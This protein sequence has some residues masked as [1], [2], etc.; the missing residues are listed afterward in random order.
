MKNCIIILL[1]VLLFPSCSLLDIEP[2][3]FVTPSNYY[4]NE[5]EMNTALNGIYATLANTT[6]FGNNLLG[7]M[8]LSADIGYESYSSD[9]GSVG[10]YDVSPTDAKILNYWRDLY[11]GI[12]RA[13]MLI[14]YI[15]KPQ[16]DRKTRDNI[17]GQALFLRA[18]YHFLLVVRFHHIPLVLTV[19]DDGKREHVQ[20]PQSDMREVYLQI[21]RD[22]EEAAR[23]V[24]PASELLSPGRASQS[25]VYGML[26][27]VALYMAGYPL[28]E[29]G[30]YAKARE[31]A[32]KVIDTGTHALNPSFEQV[33]I[34]YIQDKYDAGES[35]FEVEFWG[36]NEGTYTTTA[37]MV[38]RN[39]GIGCTSQNVT[40]NGKTIVDMYGY[41]IGTI[42]TTPYYYALFE[43][44][45]LRRDW[46]IGPYTYNTVSGQK[47]AQTS[48][49]W[50]RYCGKF[51][52]EYELT[53][54]RATN[55]TP[56]NFPLLR[57][58]DI[59]LIWA[60][61]V[62]ADAANNDPEQL[63]Q[64]YEYV[65]QVRRRGYGVDIHT[66]SDAA[67]LEAG[68]KSALLDA[69]KDER[70]RELGFE[71]LRKDDIVRWGEFYDRMRYLRNVAAAIPDSYTSSYYLSAK[72]TYNNANRRD[73]IWPI[74]T[75]ELGVNRCLVQNNGW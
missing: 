67:D 49:I 33:F 53:T 44:G 43:E 13:N 73:E 59:L 74:P 22:M 52:R 21:I 70:A 11:D 38:G 65:N 18:Y 4:N 39:N 32:Q 58:A 26:A 41:S 37:G 48:N 19:P 30:M 56:V 61:S 29:P 54:P 9:Y 36:T 2:Q 3:D 40:L 42:R 63:R 15:D 72:R 45:D 14:K 28:G 46:T 27:R 5:E 71:L 75:Y 66:P 31:Y 16:L 47:T 8:G 25:A 6:L 24:P 50:I 20:V 12:G 55:Y 64:A 35:I 60:E 69:I 57:Y 34:N 68:D 23:L 7:R 51:R 17:L 10:D 62:A 1:G